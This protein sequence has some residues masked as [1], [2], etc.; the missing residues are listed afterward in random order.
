MATV[1][2]K[3]LTYNGTGVSALFTVEP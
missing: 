2:F 1:G 3:G